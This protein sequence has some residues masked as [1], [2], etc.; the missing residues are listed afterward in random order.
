M[1]TKMV[2]VLV[3][4]ATDGFAQR[5]ATFDTMEQCEAFARGY[6]LT[7]VG[8]GRAACI[9][10]NQQ[11]STD[12]RRDFDQALTMMEQYKDRM[13]QKQKEL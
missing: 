7:N 12:L 3:I 1:L 10:E 5:F 8:F 9:P 13:R 6:N 4:M 11:A 2:F